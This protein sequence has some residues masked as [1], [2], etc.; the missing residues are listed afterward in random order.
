MIGELGMKK[1]E[2][3]GI[4]WKWNRNRNR[5]QMEMIDQLMP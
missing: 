3:S 1:M 5:N 4:E 2:W